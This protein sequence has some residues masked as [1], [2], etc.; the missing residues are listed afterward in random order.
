[1]VESE[2]VIPIEDMARINA[3]LK[4]LDLLVTPK[5]MATRETFEQ[6][7]VSANTHGYMIAIRE[8]Y[9]ETITC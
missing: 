9:F 8:T 4:L 3:L 6:L 7:F 5:N 2:S 1:M